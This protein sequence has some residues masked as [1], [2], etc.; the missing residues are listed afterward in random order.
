[1]HRQLS[2]FAFVLVVGCGGKGGGDDTGLDVTPD[3]DADT[4][5][6][7]DVPVDAPEE[8]TAGDVAVDDAAG[9]D[10][11]E[12]PA[13]DEC[14]PSGVGSAPT[15]VTAACARVASCID[16][17]DPGPVARNC[18]VMSLVADWQPLYGTQRDILLAGSARSLWI[19]VF[20][21]AA[22]VAASIDCDEAFECM[23]GGTTSPACTLASPDMGA[24][25]IDCS[26]ADVVYCINVDPS[27]VSGR[28]IVVPCAGG[29]SCQVRGPIATCFYSDCT[30]PDSAPQCRAGSIDQCIAAGTHLV[31]DC[32]ALSRGSGGAC[33]MVD[34]GTGTPVATCIPTGPSCDP[35]TFVDRCEGTDLVRCELD[36]EYSADCADV[37]TGWRCNSTS[38]ECVPDVTGWT[39]TVDESGLC[40]CDDLVFCDPTEGLDVRIDCT[41]YGMT[42]QVVD[43]EA[44]CVP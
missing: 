39:C 7:V 35:V 30:T 8:D 5:E 22:C 29:A 20:A 44:G 36:H 4:T 34:D 33:A 10:P 3:P 31:V 42:C 23:H 26:G 11:V 18:L 28:E 9:A 24:W 41:D 13:E 25:P 32:D 27:D 17:A 2:L 16:P 12:D 38:G 14:V 43:G 15:E 21:H 1:M 40:D 6:G 19:Q 37:D